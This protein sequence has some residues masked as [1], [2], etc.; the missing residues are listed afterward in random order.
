MSPFGQASDALVL[1]FLCAGALITIACAPSESDAIS[2]KAQ[3]ETI[4]EVSQS[5]RRGCDGWRL[6]VK[7]ICSRARQAGR[8]VKVLILSTYLL[9]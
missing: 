3:R 8:G 7:G 6:S 5:M 1:V 4:R 2:A 9:I